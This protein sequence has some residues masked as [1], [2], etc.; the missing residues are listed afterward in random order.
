MLWVEA[1]DSSKC[2]ARETFEKMHPLDIDVEIFHVVIQR[3][4]YQFTS[5][6]NLKI[7]LSKVQRNSIESDTNYKSIDRT[8]LFGW[9][10]FRKHSK[11]FKKLISKT[12][13]RLKIE[14]RSLETGKLYESAWFCFLLMVRTYDRWMESFMFVSVVISRA[15]IAMRMIE[16]LS[17]RSLDPA[18]RE[19]IILTKRMEIKVSSN[20][21]RKRKMY[22]CYAIKKTIREKR[23]I[24]FGH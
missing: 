12:E 16:K 15:T 9:F 23:K 13:T 2:N 5:W 22:N 24:A 7:S 19:S 18:K 4:A 20:L 10:F 14:R 1:G 6:K 3:L 17:I 11:E 8:F 21:A